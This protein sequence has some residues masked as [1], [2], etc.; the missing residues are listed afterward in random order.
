MPTLSIFYGIIV[1]MYGEKDSKH[2]LPHIHALYSGKEAVMSLDGEILEGSLPAKKI[3][4]LRVWMDIHKDE[5]E[6]NWQLLLEGEPYFKIKP[7]R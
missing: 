4:M 5:L 6:A 7:L 1:R 2:H 3:D